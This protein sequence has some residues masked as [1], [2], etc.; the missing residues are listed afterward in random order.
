MKEYL[1]RCEEVLKE[2]NSSEQGLSTGEAQQRL[3]RFGKNELEKGKMGRILALK[4]I[5]HVNETEALSFTG[6][7]T[8][9]EAAESLMKLTEN[10][11]VITNGEKGSCCLCAEDGKWYEEPAF[12]VDVVDTIGAGD[13]H[14]GTFIAQRQLGKGISESL[15]EA[16]K[17]SSMIVAS[18]GA[19]LDKANKR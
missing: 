12:K 9:R 5:L 14:I 16:N 4:P 2:Q 7:N 19:R 18:E 15:R 13:A 10:T 6:C 1:S 17:I 3:S 11:V 8:L